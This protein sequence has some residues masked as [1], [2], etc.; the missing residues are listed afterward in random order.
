MNTDYTD[1]P[2]STAYM[3]GRCARHPSAKARVSHSE[4]GSH[5]ALKSGYSIPSF[6]SDAGGIPYWI[7]GCGIHFRTCW[8]KQSKSVGCCV[9]CVIAGCVGAV[10]A[11]LPGA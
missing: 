5:Y 2:E 10:L 11:A 4:R 9:Y 7:M 6:A 3:E 8:Q 1:E